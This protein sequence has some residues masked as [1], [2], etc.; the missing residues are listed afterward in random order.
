[1]AWIQE[2][3]QV[4]TVRSCR[5]GQF[6]RAAWYRKSKAR[7][8]SVLALRIRDIAHARPR[9]GFERITVMLRREGWLVNRKRVRRLY[10][11]QGLQLRMRVRRRKH[12]C[13]HRGPVP[14]A[15]RTHERWS[16][17]FVHD[18][19]FD[20]R[21]FRVLTVV[22]QYSRQ[23]PVLEPAF[24][25]SGRSVA[26]ALERVVARLGTPASIT[27]DHGT[28][29][30]SKALEEWAWQRG[31]KL[32]FIRP[33]KPTENGHIESFNGRLRD[34]CLNVSQF[35]TIDDAREKIEAWRQD[36]NR[37]RPHSS[38]RNLTPH[39]FARQGQETRSSEGG[40]FSL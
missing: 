12:M 20:G 8:Q 35:V 10:R 31:V 27:V 39:E 6:T 24:A 11:L 29:F 33:G 23:S 22:D 4:S 25:H 28:E 3:F 30:M 13:L 34:E 32:D 37:N 5:L 2:T 15:T 38:L 40:D 19:L 1:V 9:F 7:D 17:D 36:Y 16:M 21:A 18:A 26:T 14:T